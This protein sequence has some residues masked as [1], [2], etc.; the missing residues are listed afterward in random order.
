MFFWK[1]SGECIFSGRGGSNGSANGVI[2]TKD[3]IGPLILTSIQ[4]DNDYETT[5]SIKEMITKQGEITMS[6]T[7]PYISNKDSD[8]VSSPQFGTQCGK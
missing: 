4:N 8:V 3:G 7:C 6:P 5:T 2:G 1:L